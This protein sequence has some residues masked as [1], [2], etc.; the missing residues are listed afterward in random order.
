MIDALQEL[1]AGGLL[2]AAAS[3]VRDR[4]MM[5]VRDLRVLATWAVVHSTDPTRG[6]E[7]ALARRVGNRLVAL[8]GEGTP[9]VQDFCLGEIAT[10]R[11]ICRCSAWGVDAAVARLIATEA[12]GG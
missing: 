12:G 8:G 5:E 10:A 4:R 3:V 9:G 11:G 6:P 7:G 1:D 2:A